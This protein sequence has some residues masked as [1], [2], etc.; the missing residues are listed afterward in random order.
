MVVVV[1]GRGSARICLVVILWP[2]EEFTPGFRHPVDGDG[3]KSSSQ[4]GAT[5]S[6][7]KFGSENLPRAGC[8]EKRI[9]ETRTSTSRGTVKHLPGRAGLI[10]QR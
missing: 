4:V 6:A 3:D 1:L 10:Y 9:A 7:I 2:P 8:Q 5:L